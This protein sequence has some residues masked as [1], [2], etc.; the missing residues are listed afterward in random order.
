MSRVIIRRRF[1]GKIIKILA[2]G[3]VTL[4]S[5]LIVLIVTVVL[6][7]LWDDPLSPDIEELLAASP[8]QIQVE[9]NGYFAWIGV[10]GPSSESPHAWGL[11]WYKEAIEADKSLSNQEFELAIEKDKRQQALSVEDL[12]CSQ[13]ETCLEA[14][15]SNPE[16]ARSVLIK[17]R[18]DIERGDEAINFPEYQ[19][20]WRPDASYYSR[21]PDNARVFRSLSAI[22]FALDV[23]EGHDD[24]ALLRLDREMRFHVRQMKGSVSIIHKMTAI[25]SFRTDLLLLNQYMLTKPKAARQRVDRLAAM[26]APLPPDAIRMREVFENEPRIYIRFFLTMK[27]GDF[28][29]KYFGYGSDKSEN[30][31]EYVWR[32]MY[33]PRMTANEYMRMNRAQFTIDELSGDNYRQAL[34]KS[35]QQINAERDFL[36][37]RNTIGHILT[38]IALQDYS[39]YLM[40]RDDLV[41]LY[42]MVGLQLDLIRDGV[43]DKK[44]IAYSISNAELRHPFTGN[45]PEWDSE[46]RTLSYSSLAAYKCN[47]P[48]EVRF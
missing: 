41:A 24:K 36:V 42:A 13:V 26:L 40:K 19:E 46:F 8:E 20:A 7:N 31:G 15:A 5:L 44:S 37:M 28:G 3:A 17:G 34:V 47:K 23:A 18:E 27:G 6:L 14:V 33:H 2:W 30:K 29:N 4:V 38:N 1:V 10:I 12:I 48:L 16:E 35:Q 39:G 43:S 25:S 21:V 9:N 11:R 32:F 45:A 22:R